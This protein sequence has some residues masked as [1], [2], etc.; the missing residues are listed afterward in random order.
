MAYCRGQIFTSRPITLREQTACRVIASEAWDGASFAA[1]P[2]RRAFRD[3]STKM[4]D[5]ECPKRLGSPHSPKTDTFTTG[6]RFLSPS[7]G[8]NALHTQ[9]SHTE[10]QTIFDKKRAYPEICVA[11]LEVGAV[12]SKPYRLTNS[13]C[14][15]CEPQDMLSLNIHRFGVLLAVRESQHTRRTAEVSLSAAPNR[16]HVWKAFRSVE[17]VRRGPGPSPRPNLTTKLLPSVWLAERLS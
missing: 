8:P 1:Q 12:A 7:A 11:K 15:V 10:T 5:S 14:C 2:L 3:S 4:E 13:D 17:R 16:H 6:Y 9:P